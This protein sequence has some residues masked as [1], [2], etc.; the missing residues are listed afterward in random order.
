MSLVLN[1]ILPIFAVIALGSFLKRSALIDEN[2]V[3]VSDRLIYYIFF[4][5]LL[6]WKIGRPT[7]AVSIDWRF[8][9]G[10]LFSVFTVFALSLILGKLLKIPDREVGSFSQG[11]YRFSTYIGIAV[12]LTALGENGVKEFGVLIGFVIPFINVLAVSSLIRYSG[13]NDSQGRERSFLFKSV[14]TN[15]LIISCLLGILYSNLGVPFP[16]FVEKILSMIS[17]LSL[18]LALISIGG[19]LTF[20]KFRE[21]FTYSWIAALCKLLVLPAVGYVVLRQ[22]QVTETTFQ[23][24]MIYFALPTSPQNYIL[25]SQ[26]DSDVDLATSTIVLTTMSSI[27]SLSVI[28]ILFVGRP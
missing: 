22:L 24:G 15:P 5:L 8:I 9:A 18:P 11:C 19:S 10:V 28:L 17:M 12:I 1:S 23:V 13:Q 21:H 4:P 25:S 6:F 27:L 2:F 3:R 20:T 26:L 16:V 7:E 14:L